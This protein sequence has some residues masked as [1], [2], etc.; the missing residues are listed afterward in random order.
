MFGTRTNFWL[1]NNCHVKSEISTC[2]RLISRKPQNRVLQL[3]KAYI[4]QKMMLFF[5]PLFNMLNLQF[6]NLFLFYVP[7]FVLC[8]IRLVTNK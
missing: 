6:L 2:V 1:M 5:I 3:F 4:K 8:I 7:K